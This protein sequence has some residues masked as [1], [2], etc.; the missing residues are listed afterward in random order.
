MK[1]KKDVSNIICEVFQ[2]AEE[3]LDESHGPEDIEKWD[4]LAQL[5]V[6]TAIE[7][8]FQITFEFEEVFS[9]YT[10]GDI[11]S[12]LKTRGLI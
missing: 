9:I 8:E 1:K 5:N 10:I 4:S 11:Y 2:I 7:N 6:I 3:S 12:V